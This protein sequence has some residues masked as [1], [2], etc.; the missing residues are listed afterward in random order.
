MEPLASGPYIPEENRT[1]FM[2]AV[3]SNLLE[4]HS[5]NSR[6]SEALQKRQNAYAI[7]DSI[8]DLMLEHVVNF[9]PFVHY[10]SHQ[11]IGKYTFE[12]E[13]AGNPAFYQFV[14][15]SD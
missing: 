5:V 9:H 4:I 12:T 2:T 8:G 6:L 13:R 11:M 7:V 10:G 15:V 3:F 14:E 1:N